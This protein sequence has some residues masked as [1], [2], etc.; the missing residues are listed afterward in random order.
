MLITAYRSDT[1]E[2]RFYKSTEYE[3][4]YINSDVNEEYGH[5]NNIDSIEH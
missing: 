3:M 1:D 5:P 4:P 2:K